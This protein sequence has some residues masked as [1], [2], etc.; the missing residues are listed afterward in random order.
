MK[1]L[2]PYCIW[3]ILLFTT[4]VP[5]Y[6]CTI[7]VLTNADQT[8]F[9][10][11]EDWSNPISRLWFVPAG[12]SYFGC[13]YLGFDDGLAQGGVNDQGL[14]FDWVANFNNEWKPDSTM[15]R[16]VGNPSERMLESCATVQEA[17]EFYKKYREPSFSSSRILI[18]DRTGASV[19]IGVKDGELYFDYSTISRGFG[20]GSKTLSER[21]LPSSENS[22]DN[23]ISILQACKQEGTYATKYSNIFNL[24]S[25]EITL[26]DFSTTKQTVL[27]IHKELAKGGHYYEL[28]NLNEQTKSI[29]FP[30]LPNM[31]RFLLDNYPSE[32]KDYGNITKQYRRVTQEAIS[33]Q[34]NPTDFTEEF[35]G[36]IFMEQKN[37]QKDLAQMGQ[38][39][40]VQLLD[41]KIEEYF[42]NFLFC[43]EFEYLRVL[44]WV[45]FNDQGKIAS[46]KAVD[47]ESK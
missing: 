17:M 34:L 31:Q 35:W 18:A 2:R 33:G 20:Y 15:K 11:N 19:I 6:S 21:L 13:A 43:I 4:A 29:T 41:V 39:E 27:S 40:S 47:A 1:I 9:F 16:V 28:S 14:A 45:R 23:G 32:R 36:Q 12:K 24:I 10:N 44:Q 30:L 3:F 8:L 22:I 38:L 7:F 46:I 25:G 37:M 42:K 5:V 26:L